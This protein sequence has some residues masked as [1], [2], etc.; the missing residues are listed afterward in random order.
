MMPIAVR[1]GES[2]SLLYHV[3][4]YSWN[5]QGFSYRAS[6]N[7]APDR[8]CGPAVFSDISGTPKSYYQISK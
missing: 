7:F 4:H 8:G 3:A 2:L 5:M 6:Y 1:S